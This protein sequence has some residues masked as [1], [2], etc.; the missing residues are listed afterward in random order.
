MHSSGMRTAR[1]LTISQHAL[2]ECIPACIGQGVYPSMHWEGGGLYPV[3]T[4]QG[5]VSRGVSAQGSVADTPLVD[6]MTDICKN[7]TFPRTS[8]AGG[9]KRKP[10]YFIL[11]ARNMPQ[12]II[13]TK[14]Q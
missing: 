9:N 4:V 8:F 2:G 6:R 11:N 10:E 14:R 3:Y 13:S 5:G 1:L 7:I 12:K